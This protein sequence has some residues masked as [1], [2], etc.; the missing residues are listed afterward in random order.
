MTRSTENTRSYRT[1]HRNG[2]NALI[3]EGG[4]M[5][6][7]F[8]TGVLDGFLAAGF[9]PFDLF[10]GV[11]S[12]AG[13]IA[14]YL[15]EM[16]ERNFKIYTDYSLRP[17]F[18][19][20]KRFLSGGHLM[21]LDWL[22]EITIREI[23]LDLS[24]IFSKGKSFIVCLTDVTTGKAVYRHTDAANLESALKASS[25]LPIIYRTFPR[26]QGQPFADGGIADPIP[27]QEAVN[28]GARKIMV[29]RSRPETYRKK[30]HLSQALVLWKLKAY[31]RLK[32]A[33]AKRVRNY[34]KAV[35][36]IRNPPP[37]ISIAEICPPDDFKPGRLSRSRA[38]LADGYRQGRHMADSA[39]QAWNKLTQ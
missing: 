36:L 31:P 11:S 34:N 14:A 15:A 35:S 16:Q 23:R 22:W 2:A 39:I 30:E 17:E 18:I 29:I 6:G 1:V 7:I 32:T 19:N 4:A 21:D 28:R 12:G 38:T 8:S 33:M 25:A 3:V 9:N 27:V 24:T 37:G 20:M 26:L 5:R 13:N 10:M